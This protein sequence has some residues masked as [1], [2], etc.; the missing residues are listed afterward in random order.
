MANSDEE[1]ISELINL[2]VLVVS[3]TED[4]SPSVIGEALS[5]GVR[6]IGSNVGGIPEILKKFDMPIFESENANALAQHLINLSH[7]HKVKEIRQLAKE[8]FGEIKIGKQYSE[9]YESLIQ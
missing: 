2:D 8:E 1:V 9:F 4:N 3:S 5:L 6:V 7:S